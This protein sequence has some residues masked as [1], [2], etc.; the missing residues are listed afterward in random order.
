VVMNNK[1]N[2]ETDIPK[3]VNDLDTMYLNTSAFLSPV[4]MA[5][6]SPDQLIDDKLEQN[7]NISDIANEKLEREL[8]NNE[9]ALEL[10]NK[11]LTSTS[12]NLSEDIDIAVLNSVDSVDYFTD[13]IVE[14]AEERSEICNDEIL[15]DMEKNNNARK[16]KANKQV[17]RKSIDSDF[18]PSK[19]TKKSGVNSE[20]KKERKKSQNKSAANRYRIKK[21]VEQES[22]EVELDVQV[23]QNEELQ[24]ALEKLQMEYKVVHPLAEAA[25]GGDSKRKILLQMLH[26][27]VLRDNLLD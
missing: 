9:S 19:R 24:Q 5:P 3:N 14:I 22:V 23:K 27:R 13:N 6:S 18:S 21:R 26:I 8:L 25:F 4:S 15:I 17:K 16:N 12:N 2:S 20:I 10:L 7:M 1:V 11:I